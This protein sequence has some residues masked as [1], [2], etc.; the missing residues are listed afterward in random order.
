M[1]PT[2]VVRYAEI[3]LKGLN[4]PYFERAL[5]SRMEQAL[6]PLPA[7][8]VREQGRVFVFGVP[9]ADMFST[10]MAEG[11]VRVAGGGK[12]VLAIGF[13]TRHFESH[14]IMRLA[15]AFPGAL[16]AIGFPNI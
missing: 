16:A 3:H 13:S 12:P 14:R 15:Y 10:G 11:T 8:I 9:E 7:R 2:L 1:E 6:K 5:I 4:R